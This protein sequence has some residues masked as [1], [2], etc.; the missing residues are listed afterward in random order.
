M[1]LIMPDIYTQNFEIDSF[2][3]SNDAALPVGK[4]IYHRCRN[5]Q[6]KHKKSSSSEILIIYD[7]ESQQLGLT[8]DN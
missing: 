1:S 8:I 2:Q 6:Q 3:M 7:S 4:T 5:F